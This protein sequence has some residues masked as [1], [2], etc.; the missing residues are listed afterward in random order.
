TEALPRVC[1]RGTGHRDEFGYTLAG[2]LAS[3][4]ATR[5]E[6][7][8]VGETPAHLAAARAAGVPFLG[9]ARS[10]V[11]ERQLLESGAEH[12]VGS[13]KFV[14]DALTGAAGRAPVTPC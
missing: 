14:L 5:E 11:R 9:H 12:L 7:L 10:E 1:G 6:A 2:A 8:F 4:G 13:L 3:L